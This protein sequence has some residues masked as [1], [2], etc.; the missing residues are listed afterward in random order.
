[1]RAVGE[2]PEAADASG[3][4]VYLVRYLSVF[5]GGILVSAALT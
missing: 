3:V 4:N 5:L 2:K 1:V